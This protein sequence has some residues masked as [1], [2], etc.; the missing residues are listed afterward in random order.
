MNPN[1]AMDYHRGT[2]PVDTLILKTLEPVE[3]YLYLLTL[4]LLWKIFANTIE[5][6]I[7]LPQYRF[8]NLDCDIWGTQGTVTEQIPVAQIRL[9]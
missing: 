1:K 5:K 2:V 9:S 4:H 8:N 6:K 7:Y 3:D